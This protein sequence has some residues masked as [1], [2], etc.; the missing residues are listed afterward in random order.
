ME[1][2]IF[3]GGC[4][5]DPKDK[6]DF[7]LVGI[8][9]PIV[10]PDEFYL[11][12]NFLVKYQDGIPSCTAQAQT[13]HK[14]RQ[15]NV[16]L[17]A[18]YVMAKTKEIEGN[19]DWGA[20]IRTTFK[21][22]NQF[23]VPEDTMLP[24][25]DVKMTWEEYLK[26]ALSDLIEQNAMTHRSR[27]YWRIETDH[28]SIKQAIFQNKQSVVIAIPWYPSYNKTDKDGILAQP[29]NNPKGHA[30][31][32]IGWGE[33]GLRI[34]NSFGSNWG[35]RGYFW[36]E[37]GAQRK[38]KDAWCSLDI[39]I[40]LPVD[41][42]YGQ[43]RTWTNYLKEKAVAFNTWLFKKIGRL[44]NNREINALVYGF[45]DFEAVFKGSV[46]DKWLYYTKPQYLKDFG[47]NL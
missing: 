38:I 1:N 22:V 19:T 44:P 17:S 37:D 31:E 41:V 25:P 4:L 36:Y 18:R 45:W 6:R 15:E 12:D 24:E 23:G 32:V 5:K 42:R 28:E 13:H 8:Q 35:D 29:D 14:E 27:S 46:S 34:K 20:Y 30:V 11:E 7:R 16:R 43:T 21:A 47:L 26:P 10:L 9:S 39:P 2:F 33:K 40:Q 3:V